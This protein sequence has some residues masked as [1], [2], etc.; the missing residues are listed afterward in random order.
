MIAYRGPEQWREEV[1]EEDPDH[2]KATKIDT[3]GLMIDLG[4]LGFDAALVGRL[5]AIIGHITESVTI[6]E[7]QSELVVN[8]NID[9][10]FAAGYV[11][12]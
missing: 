1:D 8:V 9:E 2:A 11:G 7:S 4:S 3:V 12:E 6:P 5:R 10:V